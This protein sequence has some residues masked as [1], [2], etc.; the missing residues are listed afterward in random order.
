MEDLICLLAT[1]RTLNEAQNSAVY[2]H[3]KASHHFFKP[4]EAVIDKEV[5]WFERGVREVIWERV[6]QPALNKKGGLP[7]QLSYALDEAIRGLP[8][9]LSRD[10]S[11]AWLS[12]EFPD[13][14]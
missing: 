7:F 12:L 8:P 1:V 13:A 3:C 2:N 10:Q 9:R 4:E 5:R 14:T 11:E 6:K